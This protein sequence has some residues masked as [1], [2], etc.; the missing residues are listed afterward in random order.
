MNLAYLYLLKRD[1]SK[2][3]A[4]LREVLRLEPANAEA[5]YRLMWLLL[6]QG[7]VDEC[8]SLGEG[9]KATQTLSAPAH[10]VL[11]DA[12]LRKGDK[13]AALFALAKAA[14]LR[15]AEPSYH[16]ALGA[17]WLRPQP[18]L[19]QAEA[20]LPPLRR[21]PARR[22]AGSTTPRLRAAQ[23]E[24]VR[25]GA[26]LVWRRASSAGRRR[27]KLITTSASS[28]RGRTRTRGR[29]SCSRRPCGRAHVRARARRARRDLPQAE[30]L[31]ARPAVARNGGEAQPRRREGALQPRHALRATERPGARARRR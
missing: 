3:A 27:P 14:E 5:G 21:T 1:P 17:A 31:P 6:S 29:W 19:Q 30:R 24:E 26:H 9:L 13:A 28:R 20:V 10:A 25:G 22:R 12:Y 15:P 4:E 2:S 16:F 7:R 11:G 18:D 8:V 23:T